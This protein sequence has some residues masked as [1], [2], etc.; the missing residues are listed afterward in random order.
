M[1]EIPIQQVLTSIRCKIDLHLF[2]KSAIQMEIFPI[3]TLD[4]PYGTLLSD[5]KLDT[6][7]TIW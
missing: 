2:V 3:E 4:F 1:L 7:G 6:R 5:T